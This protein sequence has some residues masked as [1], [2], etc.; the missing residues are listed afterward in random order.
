M[1]ELTSF[2]EDYDSFQ[3]LNAEILAISV[4]DLE[5]HRRFSEK[6]GG[7]PFPML[8]DTEGEVIRMYGVAK[9][10]GTGARRSVFI[11]DT[12]GRIVH[13]NTN[14]SVSDPMHYKVVLDTLRKA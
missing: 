13:A 14:Y 6:L 1:K 7:I 4:D 2:R 11:L 5:S 10:E 3:G 9:E 12:E 8:S